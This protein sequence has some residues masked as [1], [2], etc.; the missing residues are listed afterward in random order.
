MS[1]LQVCGGVNLLCQSSGGL[2]SPYHRRG[3]GRL[4]MNL[5][6]W[7]S[8]VRPLRLRMTLEVFPF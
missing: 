1:A 3:D 2:K 4:S 7:F 8:T 5:L 6:G